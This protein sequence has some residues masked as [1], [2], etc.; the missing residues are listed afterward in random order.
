MHYFIILTKECNLFC[1]YCG[2]GSDTPPRE[3][4]YSIAGPQVVPLPG[5][6]TRHRVLRRRA[7]P[8]HR[9]PWR[10]SWTRSRADSSSRRTAS[11]WTGVEPEYLS[12]FHSILVSIDG[13]KEVTDRERGKGV[14]ERVDPKRGAR[15]DRRAS[16]GTSWPG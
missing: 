5:R 11:S 15:Q 12:R 13:T 1:S 14:Y 10:A 16:A 3:I 7:A 6:G 2:G 8:P 9:G 4:Q